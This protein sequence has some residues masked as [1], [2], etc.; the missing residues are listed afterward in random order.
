M[1]DCTTLPFR[2]SL[3]GKSDV[4]VGENV[5]YGDVRREPGR[6]AA[7]YQN[8]DQMLRSVEGRYELTERPAAYDFP[9]SRRV[10]QTY[11]RAGEVTET[12][13]TTSTHIYQNYNVTKKTIEQ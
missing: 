8:I 6:E 3:S 7:V 13:S 10:A 9:V 12:R 5:A 2:K 11:D 1:H 4:T